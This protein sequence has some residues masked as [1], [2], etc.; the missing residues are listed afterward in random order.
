LLVRSLDRAAEKLVFGD[1]VLGLAAVKGLTLPERPDLQL[2]LKLISGS[3]SA[4]I[5]LSIRRRTAFHAFA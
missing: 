2:T 1:C 3:G 4:A 5:A